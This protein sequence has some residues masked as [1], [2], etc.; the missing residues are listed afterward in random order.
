MLGILHDSRGKQAQQVTAPQCV[1]TS[2]SAYVAVKKT[3]RREAIL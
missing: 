2:V 3:L 1:L